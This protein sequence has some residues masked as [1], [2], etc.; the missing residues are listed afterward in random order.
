MKRNVRALLAGALLVAS[1]GA[2]AQAWPNKPVRVVVSQTAG[3]APDII[4]RLLADRLS[5]A[6]GQNFIVD[7]RP[8]GGNVIGSQAAARSAPDGYNFFFATAAAL[9]TNPYTFKSLPYDPIRDFAPVSMIG[10]S[11]FLFL[12]N[13]NVPVKTLADVVALDKSAPGKLSFAS[14]GPKGFAGMLGEWMNKVMGTKILQVPYNATVQGI[15]DTLGGRIQFTI[16]AITP[17]LPFI[18][19]GELK[20]IAS[21]SAT[22]P[23]GFEDV[24]TVGET[25][26]GFA[27]V[28]WF[29][30]V[31]PT[32]TPAAIVTQMNREMDKILRDPEITNRLREFG[33]YTDGADTPENTGAFIRSELA[34]W[35][36]VIK[37]IGIQPE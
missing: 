30:M 29:V 11:P 28:G 14:D 35:G 36:R 25:F 1:M 27:F 8:G 10:K 32:G 9:V 6:T 5:K 17:S 16:Q 33:V 7:N 31:A 13:P 34:S 4:A 18:R 21:S 15:Q 26:P 23:P 24:Q 20:V 19:R 12:A 22:R 2:H 3:A 37:E